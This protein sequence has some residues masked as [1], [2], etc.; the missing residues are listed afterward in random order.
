MDCIW[1][2]LK[3]ISPPFFKFMANQFTHVCKCHLHSWKII[4]LCGHDFANESQSD[5]SSQSS[6]I[7][8]HHLT[9]TRNFIFIFFPRK[10]VSNTSPEGTSPRICDMKIIDLI[11]SILL[12]NLG[13]TQSLKKFISKTVER[14]MLTI[15]ALHRTSL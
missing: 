10:T 4:L 14:E 5:D 13:K 3:N 12:H 7:K 2:N 8:L 15:N 1:V 11:S 6:K 9:R